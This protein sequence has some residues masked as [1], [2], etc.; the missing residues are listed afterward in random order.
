M[1]ITFPQ[2]N[3]EG[4]M[5]HV[6]LWWLASR[7]KQ[8]DSIAEIGSWKG[9][10]TYTLLQHCPGT[11]YAIDHF[12]GSEDERDTFHVEAKTGDIYCQFMANCGGFPNLKV[13]RGTSIGMATMLPQ[14]DMV[15]I[16]GSHQ[17]QDVMSDIEMYMPK[18][19]KLICGHDYNDERVAKAV[20]DT[21]GP[22]KFGHGSI[23]FKEL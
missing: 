17:Y 15:F 23:W 6:E 10:S 3:I 9:R 8:M 7:A 4:W 19:K 2:N 12:E 5:A 21:L 1:P 16:D 11:V 13:L 14:V 20:Y 22:V 18:A